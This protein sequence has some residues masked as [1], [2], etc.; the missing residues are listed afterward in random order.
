M[1]DSNTLDNLEDELYDIVDRI[2]TPATYKHRAVKQLKSLIAKDRK[3]M[4]EFVEEAIDK[5]TVTSVGDEQTDI[6]A[7][8][9]IGM[10][11]QQLKAEI[12]QRAKEW[13][14]GE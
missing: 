1:T 12:R 4:L 9:S 5:N 13:R 6:V 8:T 14:G 2:P 11:K 10:Y 7:Q 3:Q